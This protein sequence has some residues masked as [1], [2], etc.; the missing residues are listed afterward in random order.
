MYSKHFHYLNVLF[1]IHSGLAFTQPDTNVASKDSQPVSSSDVFT[2]AAVA[3]SSQL[4]N[5]ANHVIEQFAAALGN[6]SSSTSIQEN[7][8]AVNLFKSVVHGAMG[9]QLYKDVG[10]STQMTQKKLVSMSTAINDTLNSINDIAD[11]LLSSSNGALKFADLRNCLQSLVQ[12]GGLKDGESCVVQGL[13]I[14]GISEILTSV[15]KNFGDGIIPADIL[16]Y[17]TQALDPVMTSLI[18]GE[19]QLYLVLESAITSVQHSIVGELVQALDD[20]LK[21]FKSTL[22][23]PLSYEERLRNT[24]ACNRENYANQSSVFRDLKTLYLS[25]TNQFVGYVT[26][27]VL[28]SIHSISDS[29]LE[30]TFPAKPDEF[31]FRGSISSSVKSIVAS[32]SGNEVTYAYKI[33]DCLDTV[34]GV[35]DPEDAKNKAATAHCLQK[36]DGPLAPLRQIVYG[37]IEQIY[38]VLP[39]KIAREIEQAGILNLDRSSPDYAQQVEILHERFLKTDPGPAYVSC[40]ERV[41]DCLFNDQAGGILKASKNQTQIACF[42]GKACEKTPDGKIIPFAQIRSS[43]K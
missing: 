31:F 43:Y 1:Y 19:Q 29:Y 18:P 13:S 11:Q 36:P 32:N 38:G 41:T 9:Y 26:P 10:N 5:D 28:E 35:T 4:K 34:V 25:I 22:S 3:A 7:S 8:E 17:T 12:Q 24:R 30:K 14:T 16:K 21:C 15:L 33:A 20:A 2:Y 23:T 42:L 6:C 39:V 27:Q 40:Y 37:Y